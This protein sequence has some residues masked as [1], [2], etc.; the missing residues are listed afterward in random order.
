MK[1]YDVVIIGAGSA[2][3]SARRIIEK[4]TKN[5]LVVDHGILGTTCA[6]VGCM[7]SKVLIQTA[8]DFHRRHKLQ[9][10][11]ILGGESLSVDTQQ[12]MAHTRKLRDRF[13]GDVTKSMQE[14]MTTH[15]RA[16]KATFIDDHTLDLEGEKIAAEKIIIA[17]GS[18]PMIPE[19]WKDFSEYFITSDQIFELPELPSS[20]ATIG[21]GVIGVELGQALNRLG[22]KS[23]GIAARKSIAGLSDPELID[24]FISTLSKEMPLDFTGVKEFKKVGS[25]I[26]ITTQQ[27][28]YLVDRILLSVGRKPQLESLQ[29]EKTGLSLN[30]QGMPNFNPHTMQIENSN[31][32]IA[33]DVN[34]FRPLLHEASDEGVIAALNALNDNNMPYGRRTFL[35]VTFSD[36]NVAVVGKSYR[37][38]I[39]EQCE[40]ITGQVS[41]EGQG[42]SLVKLKNKGILKIYANKENGK[43]LGSEMIGPSIEHLAHLVSWSIQ[44]DMSTFDM[45]TM[46]FY[47]PVV[48]EGLRT[49]LREVQSQI[50]DDV[51]LPAYKSEQ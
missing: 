21:L 15:F 20:I 48:E 10:Q 1:K 13:V 37:D 42:R 19:Q 4:K 27:Q 36:P 2:G 29:F 22:T 39:T 49:A 14:W 18:R 50:S 51:T 32:Y 34:K 31:I 5:Y 30:S 45:L 6:R 25:K 35:G 38:L 3:L 23:V 26:E 41:F 28:T 17:T 40:F 8:N 16:K 7:P 46:P 47:H 9:E 24:Y 44:Q 43:I 12:V 11:G 33:G